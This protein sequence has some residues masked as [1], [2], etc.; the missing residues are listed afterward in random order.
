MSQLKDSLI[1]LADTVEALQNQPAPKPQINDRSLSGNKIN[2]GK[3]TN[4]SSVGIKDNSTYA[5]KE[6]LFVEND[7]IIVP[8]IETSTITTPLT[9]QGNLTVEGEVH[10]RKL[11][12]DEISA[13]VRN[14]RTTPLEFKAENGS[15]TNKGLL[16]TGSADGRNRQLTMQSNPERLLSFS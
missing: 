1:A 10:A 7:R 14:E 5:G 12:V 4:F 11:H 13:D 9:V 6:V 8:A 2:G 15:V 3:I 16:W